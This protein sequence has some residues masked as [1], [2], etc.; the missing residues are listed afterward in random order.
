M[1]ILFSHLRDTSFSEIQAE[2]K[3]IIILIFFSTY[4]THPNDQNPILYQKTCT[5]NNGKPNSFQTRN[6][7]KNS[8][9]VSLFLIMAK[10]ENET[11]KKRK[12]SESNSSSSSSSSSAPEG[13]TSESSWL[14]VKIEDGG[15]DSQIDVETPPPPSAA[16][17]IQ[18]IDIQRVLVLNLL[19]I[20]QKKCTTVR[21]LIVQ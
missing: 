19:P 9:R 5:E 1:Y 21:L 2:L 4:F 18:A 11:N 15:A 10:K 7:H 3:R 8:P 6:L 16:I 20:L 17:D 13:V 12:A 14:R